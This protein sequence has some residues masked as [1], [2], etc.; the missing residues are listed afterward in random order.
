MIVDAEDELKA[1]TGFMLQLHEGLSYV[2]NLGYTENLT[3]HYDHFECQ[4]GK[5]KLMPSDFM[6][7]G[8]MRF[9]NTSDPDDQS[10]LYAVSSTD[11]KT[12]GA[13]VESYGLYHEDLSSEMIERF[14]KNIPLKAFC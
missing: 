2:K 5:V 9:E 3:P 7:D 12:K 6:V 14:K 13:Y 8:V 4:S 11:G 10:I 1:G